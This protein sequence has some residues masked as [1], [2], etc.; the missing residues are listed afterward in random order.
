VSRS[1]CSRP[2]RIGANHRSASSGLSG[3]GNVS[4]SGPVPSTGPLGLPV[5]VVI[6]RLC[7]SHRLPSWSIAH[8]MSCGPPKAAAACLANRASERSAPDGMLGAPS[9]GSASTTRPLGDRVAVQPSSRPLTSRSGPPSQADSSSRS[10]RPL[11]GSAPKSTPPQRGESW[12]CTRTAMGAPVMSPE[13]AEARTSS[14]ACTN[15]LESVTSN[16]DVNTPAMEDVPPSSLVDEERTTTGRRPSSDI[17]RH[18]LHAGPSPPCR[19]DGCD[20]PRWSHAVVSTMP[21]STGSP[22]RWAIARLAAFA[23]VSVASP[24]SAWAR[25]TRPGRGDVS[26]AAACEPVRACRLSAACRAPASARAERRGLPT[27]R[28]R[29]QVIAGSSRCCWVPRIVAGFGRPF[30]AT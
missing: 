20:Q 16:T 4:A 3:S 1:E 27:R 29:V 10:V 15:E 12:G 6:G 25:S 14:T 9:A 2:S 17:W 13:R 30:V 11:M 8:S 28:A 24:A 26:V 7:S 21:G 22:A 18:A 23:P 19:R 5:T